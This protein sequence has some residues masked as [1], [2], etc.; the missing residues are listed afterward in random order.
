M[1]SS[2]P[3]TVTVCGVIQSAAVNVRLAGDTAPSAGLLDT[4]GTVT[5]PVGCEF[6]TTVNVTDVPVSDVEVPVGVPMTIAA[7]SSSAFVNGRSGR[8]LPA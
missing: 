2:T 8:P 3:V 1:R 7:V 4:S 5:S 6:R